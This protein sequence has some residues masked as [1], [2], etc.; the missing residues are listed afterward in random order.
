MAMAHPLVDLLEGGLSQAGRSKSLLE[1][2]DTTI[3]LARGLHCFSN[4]QL[5]FFPPS[6]SIDWI[7]TVWQALGEAHSPR[8]L[9]NESELE[10]LSASQDR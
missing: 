7:Y 4:L 10:V 1:E 3:C 8:V 9:T 5:S 2:A 6:T